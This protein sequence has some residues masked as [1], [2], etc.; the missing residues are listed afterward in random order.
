MFELHKIYYSGLELE[1]SEAEENDGYPWG[2]VGA[3]VYIVFCVLSAFDS[4][5]LISKDLFL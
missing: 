4:S 1:R 5:A 3:P 2:I